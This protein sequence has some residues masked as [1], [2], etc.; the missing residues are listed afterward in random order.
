MTVNA[1][2][3]ERDAKVNLSDSLREMPAFGTSSGPRNSNNANTVAGTPGLDLVNLRQLGVNR[4]LV[5]FD[6]Q[7][8]IR[9]NISGGVDLTT[10]PTALVQRVD[11]VTG[12]ASAAWGSDAVAGVVNVVLNRSF[13]GFQ[14]SVE[15]GNSFQNDAKSV[16][17]EVSYGGNFAEDR[18]HVMGSVSYLYAPDKA[19]FATRKWFR[20]GRLVNNPAYNGGANGRPRLIS[21]DYVGQATA[22]QGGLI[23]G[24]SNNGTASVNCALRG[25]QFIGPNATPAPFNFG[26]ISGAFSWGGSAETAI[27]DMMPMTIPMR[28]VTAYSR[29]SYKLT[30][31]ITAAV[32]LNYGGSI[33]KSNSTV[34]NRLGNL[35]I[36]QDN[37]FLPAS[38]RSQM[39]ALGFPFIMLGTN[40][41]NNIETNGRNLL[42]HNLKA[43]QNSLGIPVARNRRELKRAVVSL[44]GELGN[45][46][47]WT[48]YYQKARVRTKTNV[49]S[50]VQFSRYNLAVDAVAVTS[51]NVGAS[52]LPIG[53]IACRSTLTNPTN[54]CQPLNVFGHGV[55]SQAA[56]GYITGVARAGG[57]FGFSTIK[58]DAASVS[59]SGVL[60]E[61]WSLPAGPIALAFG[62]DWRKEGAINTNDPI[63][64]QTG[65]N[66][67]NFA[68]FQG[69]YN[70]KEAYGEITV[71]ILRDSFVQ[72]LD[73]NGAG[74][75]TDY[76]TSGGVETWKVGATS[77]INND[78]RLRGTYSFDIRAPILSELFAGGFR[79]QTQF[80]DPFTGQSVVGF[81]LVGGNPNLRPEESTTKSG[82]VVYRPSFVPGLSLSLDY[83]SIS[84]K[85]AI[86]T[87]SANTISTQ[88]Q[89]G[90]QLYCAQV[91]T[92]NGFV[93]I[94]TV[95]IN[96][97]SQA[98][99]GVDFQAD[100]TREVLDGN[101]SL[102]MVGNYI[103]KQSQDAQGL[104]FDY[105]GSIGADSPVAGIPQLRATLS[106]T[107]EKG[108]WIA[109][110]QGRLIGSAKKN[111][112]W[113]PLDVDDNSVPAIGYLDLRMSY[114]LK[115]NVQVYGAIDNV[116]DVQPPR[117][118]TSSQSIYSVGYRDSI[119]DAIGAS[120]RFGLKLKY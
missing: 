113:G 84:I 116:L 119:Y 93:Q 77:Q 112:A 102:H 100:Y 115:D 118:Y 22:T 75:I 41:M 120:Y 39:Q 80:I 94:S 105:A 25:I 6:G 7:R 20:P 17:T 57:N 21:Q 24:C 45:D 69:R 107:Y 76:S 49:I 3:L 61:R 44:D 70:V 89:A 14:T 46:W 104:S 74:R 53:S 47:S 48:A 73:L 97:N 111:N 16:K 15:A 50:N 34:Y 26:N 59:I 19:F 63:S 106:S 4:T 28:T 91:S 58:E 108:D 52:G 87:V 103:R 67:G 5:L 98:T 110:I 29:G 82:G 13:T 40:N 78:I 56:I 32:E 23:T 71:P 85:K 86:A 90:N 36:S 42:N 109:T 65:W 72:A 62:A 64:A 2:M 95:P 81:N 99:S 79:T 60:P 51:A 37:A 88:C 11:V 31:T 27:H 33:S 96:A 101:L 35:P 38:I 68:A 10:M 83:Y 30:D 66:I 18:G 1:A 117:V 43:E 12:G 55:A 8:V 92:V 9:S 54:G 114:K